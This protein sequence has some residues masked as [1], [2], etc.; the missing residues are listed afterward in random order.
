MIFVRSVTYIISVTPTPIC[1]I[2]VTRTVTLESK[3]LKMSKKMQKY[4]N[5]GMNLDIVTSTLCDTVTPKVFNSL[6]PQ[7]SAEGT[8]GAPTCFFQ[9]LI[10]GSVWAESVAY[11]YLTIWEVSWK[12][13]FDSFGSLFLSF[14]RISGGFAFAAE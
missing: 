3:N 9:I 11:W 13:W 5:W 8:V 6:N 1:H 4:D 2:C 14:N 12:R 10:V 7:M